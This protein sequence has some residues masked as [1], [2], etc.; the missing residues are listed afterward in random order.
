MSDKNPKESF[1]AG[2]ASNQDASVQQTPALTTPTAVEQP[3]AMYVNK[4]SP[5][6]KLPPELRAM[7]Y[8]LVLPFDSD[9]KVVPNIIVAMRG[10]TFLHH[11]AA[12]LYCEQVVLSG[13]NE[14]LLNSF[15]DAELL[16]IEEL[17]MDF[18]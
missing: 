14:T 18:R 5:L 4:S 3:P 17:T 9:I 1:E 16:C 11:E 6:H 10:S 2:E 15:S 8:Q 12:S 13:K 7:I